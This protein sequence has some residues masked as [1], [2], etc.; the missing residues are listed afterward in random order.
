MHK[1]S[2]QIAEYAIN[3]E[4]ER[5]SNKDI[6]YDTLGISNFNKCFTFAFI[7]TFDNI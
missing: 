5:R 4:Q 7:L 3:I 6:E 1:L 2:Y